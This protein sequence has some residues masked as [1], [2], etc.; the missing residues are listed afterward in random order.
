[1]K[2]ARRVLLEAAKRDGLSRACVDVFVAIQRYELMPDGARPSI[3]SLARDASVAPRTATACVARL[4]RAGWVEVTRKTRE[5]S[6]Y[7]SRPRLIVDHDHRSRST[8]TRSDITSSVRSL[9]VISEGDS[10]PHLN[11]G[12]RIPPASGSRAGARREEHCRREVADVADGGLAAAADAAAA[13]RR[14]ETTASAVAPSAVIAQNA[15]EAA[16]A[17]ADRLLASLLTGRKRTTT[18][19]PTGTVPDSGARDGPRIGGLGFG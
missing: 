3:A 5:A 11:G 7:V 4:E 1:M 10:L 15:D 9:E 2:I 14:G 8:I 18:P 17:E 6:R 19:D 12:E 13:P 16:L